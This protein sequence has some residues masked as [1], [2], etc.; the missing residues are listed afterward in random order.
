[1]SKQ[2]Y[3]LVLVEWED[4]IF[5][6]IGWK[7]ISNHEYKLSA[8]V[9]VGFL[10]KSNKNHIVLYSS[11]DGERKKK[12]ISGAGDIVIPKSAIKSLTYLTENKEPKL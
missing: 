12:Y 10:V 3:K 7:I 5:G 9:S 2:K 1:M 8:C 11:I 4:S 6:F